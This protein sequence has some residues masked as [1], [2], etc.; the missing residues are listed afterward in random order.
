MTEEEFVI[1]KLKQQVLKLQ[2]SLD[3][4]EV[5]LRYST[6]LASNSTYVGPNSTKMIVI[7]ANAL[8]EE[9]TNR[10]HT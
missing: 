1:R 8:L 4:R 9:Y 3:D 5:W 2:E 7:K 10:F 6:A